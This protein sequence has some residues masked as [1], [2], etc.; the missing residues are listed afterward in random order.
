MTADRPMMSDCRVYGHV[1]VQWVET[2]RYKPE[3]R[4]FDSRF[5]PRYGPEVDLASN[6]NENQEYS[7][8]SK[9]GWCLGLTTLP[10]SHADCLEIWETQTPGILRAFPGLYRDWF[11]IQHSVRWCTNREM[12][13]FRYSAAFC[14]VAPNVCGSDVQNFVDISL[15]ASYSEWREKTVQTAGV[16]RSGRENRRQDYVLYVFEFFRIFAC[17]YSSA[18]YFNPENGDSSTLRNVGTYLPITMF[19]VCRTVN[20]N[21]I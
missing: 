15:L 1:V 10:Y 21:L 4:G 18:E 20:L 7:L 5:R 3:G 6:R 13:K 14:T 17:E 2:L 11:T 12:H 8:G 9:G 19:Y 16:R